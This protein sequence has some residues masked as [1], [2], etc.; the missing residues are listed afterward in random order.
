M[1][2]HDYDHKYKNAGYSDSGFNPFSPLIIGAF[3]VVVALFAFLMFSDT[4][5]NNQ[6][7]EFNTAPPATSTPAPS[8]PAEQGPSVIPSTP[9][10]SEQ[11]KAQ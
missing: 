9:P 7:A 6:Q 1:S 3:A 10:A 11:P 2:H 8:A 5:G 4:T